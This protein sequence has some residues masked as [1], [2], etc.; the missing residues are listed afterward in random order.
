MRSSK[1]MPGTA[2]RWVGGV[3]GFSG[4]GEV[5][6]DSDAGRWK[7]G[8]EMVMV[9]VRFRLVGVWLCWL[10]WERYGGR[11]RKRVIEVCK[12]DR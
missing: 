2:L 9:G 12:G 6:G 11:W 3:S 10:H 7:R 8:G 4:G 1:G 5:V